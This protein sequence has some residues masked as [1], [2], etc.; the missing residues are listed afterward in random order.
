[1]KKNKENNLDLLGT[2]SASLIHEINNPVAAI[3]ARLELIKS[4]VKKDNL[5]KDKLLNEIETINQKI[6]KITSIV[7][8]IKDLSRVNDE[9]EFSPFLLEDVKNKLSNE[10]NVLAS[11]SKVKIHWELNDEIY[12]Y[13]DLDE[14]TLIAENLVKNAIDE[15]VGGGTIKIKTSCLDDSAFIDFIDSGKGVAST[16]IDSLFKPFKT[17]KEKGKGTGLGLAVSKSIAQR[18]DGDL[19]YL[20][21]SKQTTFR[22]ILKKVVLDE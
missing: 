13:A 4:Y 11:E 1:M 3:S 5:D 19:V 14:I 15:L 2:M 20:D 16:Y 17:S 7:S 8:T 6:S 12:F 10:L 22:L 18:N 21:E 9:I